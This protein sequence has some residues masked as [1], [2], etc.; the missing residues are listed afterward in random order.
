MRYPNG[1]NRT[2]SPW[3][4]QTCSG[5]LPFEHLNSRR[6][7]LVASS[8]SRAALRSAFRSP[9]NLERFKSIH[10]MISSSVSSFTIRHHV[11]LIHSFKQFLMNEL[12]K[13]GQRN[14]IQLDVFNVKSIIAR[15]GFPF[16]S[17]CFSDTKKTPPSSRDRQIWKFIAQNN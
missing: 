3:S 11:M 1:S 10:A 13:C 7:N 15:S 6:M 14:A 2:I 16:I 5:H 9:T 4:R 12:E 8:V 17:H